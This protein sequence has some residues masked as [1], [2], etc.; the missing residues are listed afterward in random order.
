MTRLKSSTDIGQGVEYL[1]GGLGPGE[2]IGVL[3]PVANVGPGVVTISI[4][5]NECVPRVE[6]FI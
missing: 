1:P 5:P 3:D 2:W 4:L 6:A